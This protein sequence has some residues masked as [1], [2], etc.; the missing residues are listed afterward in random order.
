MI[1]RPE[2]RDQIDSKYK[3]KIETLVRYPER[4]EIEEE[5][6]PCP[7]CDFRLLEYGLGCPGCQLSIPY[8]IVTVSLK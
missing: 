5:L 3:K 7:K 1:L 6:T 2:Y 8:C 4:S